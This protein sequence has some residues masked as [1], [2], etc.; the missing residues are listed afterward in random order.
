MIM[1]T[2]LQHLLIQLNTFCQMVNQ[3]MDLSY[4]L[5]WKGKVLKMPYKKA[6]NKTEKTFSPMLQKSVHFVH[7]SRALLRAA[8]C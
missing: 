4:Q 1:G 6:T 3:W 7:R 8:L 2:F 5:H